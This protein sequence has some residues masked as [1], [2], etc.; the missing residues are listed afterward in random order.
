MF[1]IELQTFVLIDSM[2]KKICLIAHTTIKNNIVAW[3][4]QISEKTPK[5]KKH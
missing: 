1:A 3:K 4:K 5:K 2:D